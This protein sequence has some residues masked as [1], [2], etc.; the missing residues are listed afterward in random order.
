MIPIALCD[1]SWVRHGDTWFRGYAHYEGRFTSAQSLATQLDEC[2]S[3]SEWRSTV[4][5][6]NGCFA[7]VTGR[8]NK[9]LAA[10]DRIR[11]IPLFYSRRAGA[12]L[13]SDRA[14]R[15]LEG[16]SVREVDPIAAAEFGL[17]GYVTGGDTLSA[18]VGQ[19]AA[20]EM[21]VFDASGAAPPIR[22]PY[23]Q[24][25]H[26]SFLREDASSLISKLES[27]HYDVFRRLAESA[28]GRTIAI[29]LSGGYDSRLIGVCLRDMGVRNVV[30]Y[31]Y[32]VPGN[33]ESGISRELAKYLGFKWEFVP[34]TADRWRK[35]AKSEAYQEY[36]RSA[37][38]LCSTPHIQDW[39]AV[40]ELRKG[41]RVP[42]DSIFVPGHSG[43]FLA[44]SHIPK[45]YVERSLI[46]CDELLDS[47]YRAH[48]S[49]WDWPPDQRLQL[50]SWFKTRIEA[51][52]GPL[53]DCAPE[54]AAD[55]FERWDLQER[56]AKFIC[57]SVRV[58]ESL[59]YDW[60]LPLFD[61]ELM[62]FWSRIPIQWRVGRKLYFEF[63]KRRQRLPITEANKDYSAPI[64]W[65]LKAVDAAGMKPAAKAVQRLVRRA[66]WRRQY[67]GSSLAW[68]ATISPDLVR[69]TYT[70]K[71]LF[72]S[73][74]SLQYLDLARSELRLD[75]ASTR[76][77]A[78]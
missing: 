53:D 62:D 47:L 68:Y 49:L 27:V 75:R 59:G 20:G 64:A 76:K 10:V 45:W 11:T 4:V 42:P 52:T 63:V 58:Y 24:Y 54:Q 36:F 43:D 61:H 29:P 2:T 6:L 78:I 9:V 23:H 19:L 71:E 60:R 51:V 67:E 74:L 56:Q 70:G 15:I 39:P 35:W 12:C 18:D 31:S 32:G 25:R 55:L 65:F 38:N 33:W 26:H 5:H 13:V 16:A 48:Y 40:L 30:C 3:D 73:Y 72:Y 34:Y 46:G 8:G 21:A 17:T 50:Q 77:P 66:T 69:R 41:G 14:G 7:A 28:D 37:G 57:N 22:H 44:G 1:K